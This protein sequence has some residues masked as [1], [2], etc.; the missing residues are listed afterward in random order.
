M[1]IRIQTQFQ[2]QG[3]D[4]QKFKNI[5]SWNTFNIFWSKIEIFLSLGRPKGRTSYMRSFQPSKKNIQLLR[6]WKF[7]TF[8]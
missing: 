1:R 4:D 7:F 5:Y 6:T 2:I 3:F 8:F